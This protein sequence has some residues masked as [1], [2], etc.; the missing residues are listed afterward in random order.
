MKILFLFLLLSFT[1]SAPAVSAQ[2]LPPFVVTSANGA[3]A[4]AAAVQAAGPWV[5]AYVVPDSAPSNRLVRSLAEHWS[6]GQAA[7]IVFIVSG[8]PEAAKAYLLSTGGEALAGARWY[9][10]PQGAAW[11]ALK[12]DGALAVAGIDGGRIDWKVDGVIMDPAVLLPAVD[13]WLGG[14]ADRR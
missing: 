14:G 1:A 13:K 3:P 4:D 12:F 7:R 11:K 6:A 5:L 9:A 8:T 2:E 10:D